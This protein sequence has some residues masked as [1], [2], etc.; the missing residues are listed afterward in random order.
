LRSIV[1]SDLQAAIGAASDVVD[2]Y[3]R[4]RFKLPLTAWGSDIRR[5]CAK[6]AV[7]DLMMVRGFNSSRAGDEQIQRQYDDAVQALRD[8]S[9]EKSTPNVTDS[10][11]GAAPGEVHGGGTVQVHSYGSRGYI[12]GDCQR[13]GAFQ[14]R[15]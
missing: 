6:I 11:A 2:S 4:S 1:D 5:L 10:S 14:G 7:Y 3:L 9:N 8:I 15:R 12:V 13:G